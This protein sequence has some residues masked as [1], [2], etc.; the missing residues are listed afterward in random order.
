MPLVAPGR[1]LTATAAAYVARAEKDQWR[2]D[3]VAWVS[4]RTPVILW[5]RQR[6]VLTALA[7]HDRVAVRACHSSSKTMSAALAAAWWLDIW[8]AGTAR[9][10]T[11]AP[12]SAQIRGQLWPEVN[13]LWETMSGLPGRVNQ[14]EIWIGSWLAGVGRKSSDYQPAAM[15]GWHAEHLLVLVDEADGISKALWMAI[16]SLAT[17]VGAKIL[18]IGNPDD[19]QSEF[20]RRQS[21]QGMGGAYHTIR[22]AATDTPNFTGEPTSPLLQRVLL[23]RGWVEEMRRAWGGR[24]DSDEPPDHPFWS[25]KVEAE[26]PDD[27]AA[28][29]IR[30]SDL[31]RARRSE[32]DGPLAARDLRMPVTVGV[33]VAGSE[34]GDE[35]VVRG[36]RGLRLLGQMTTRTGDPEE[37]EDWLMDQLDVF[38]A[39][40]ANIDADGIGFGFVAA[41]RR[42]RPQVAVGEIRSG[43]A[44][45]DPKVYFNRRAEMWWNL[46]QALMAD[47][48]E[49]LDFT[50]LDDATAAQL[51][52]PRYTKRKGRLLVEAKEDLRKRL[53]RSPDNADALVYRFARPV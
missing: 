47:G 10:V 18:A 48:D 34:T 31:A 37:L 11:T 28:T 44:A 42:R 3:P 29:V 38:G 24:V 33:D 19:P 27:Q 1:V 12:T 26:Y 16:D 46:R 41:A 35:S 14:T 36:G 17:N 20:R 52:M 2:R 21:D 45:S 13:H 15:Q 53:G 8:P 6:E 39:R 5:S 22:I 50:I 4:E 40:Q 51:L 43:V 9:V 49:Q 23:S 30:V 7:E 25:S 32:R